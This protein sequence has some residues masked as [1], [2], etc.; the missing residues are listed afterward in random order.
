MSAIRFIEDYKSVQELIAGMK[1]QHI[2]TLVSKK[3][4]KDE[5]IEISDAES[6]AQEYSCGGEADLWLD[7]VTSPNHLFI[8]QL[9]EA[10]NGRT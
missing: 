9:K 6:F 5:H 7:I 3:V 10:I 4:L 8:E 1:E 2:L